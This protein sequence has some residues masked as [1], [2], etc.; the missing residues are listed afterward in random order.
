MSAAENTAPVPA[1]DSLRADLAGLHGWAERALTDE[2]TDRQL[3][4]EYLSGATAALA[5][6]RPM[7]R[8]PYDDTDEF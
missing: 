2:N 4:A 7:A 3:I 1:V 8:R 6:G 5:D